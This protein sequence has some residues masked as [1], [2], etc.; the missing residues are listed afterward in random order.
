MLGEVERRNIFKKAQASSTA[1]HKD[2][3]KEVHGRHVHRRHRGLWVG[4]KYK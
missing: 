1:R 3:V 2:K 4:G